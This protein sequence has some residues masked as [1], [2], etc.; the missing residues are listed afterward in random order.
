MYM[1]GFDSVLWNPVSSYNM[2][3]IVKLKRDTNIKK[4]IVGV[5]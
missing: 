4:T 1:V 5:G 3:K 2:I